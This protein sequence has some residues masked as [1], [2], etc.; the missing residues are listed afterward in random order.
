MNGKSV[1]ISREYAPF[2]LAIYLDC[3]CKGSRP[4][5]SSPRAAKHKTKKPSSHI[6]T[7]V[8]LTYIMI[9]LRQGFS[10]HP[11]TY[12]YLGTYSTAQTVQTTLSAAPCR[13][14]PS[15]YACLTYYGTLGPLLLCSVRHPGK[16][17]QANRHSTI[18][19]LCFPVGIYD[20]KERTF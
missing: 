7:Q 18:T 4:S 16:K 20:A 12:K 3:F 5:R 2:S 17:Q 10:V 15:T 9:T 6:P 8:D 14:S 1:R 11:A 13:V 19:R